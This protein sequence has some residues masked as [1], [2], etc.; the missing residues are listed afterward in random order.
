M[1]V[2]AGPTDSALAVGTAGSIVR[3]ISGLGRNPLRSAVDTCLSTKNRLELYQLGVMDAGE[4]CEYLFI[5]DVLSTIQLC[6]DLV[7]NS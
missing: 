3:E 6:L 2:E 4:N 7:D 1:A 5:C